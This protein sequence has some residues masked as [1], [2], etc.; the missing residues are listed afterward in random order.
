MLQRLSPASTTV[1]AAVIVGGGFNKETIMSC[2]SFTLAGCTFVIHTGNK[3]L[4]KSS[5]IPS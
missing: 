2:K 4:V 3:S 1:R 5:S